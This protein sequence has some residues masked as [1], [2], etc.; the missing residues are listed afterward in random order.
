MGK[1]KGGLGETSLISDLTK[2][3]SFHISEAL[4]PPPV[5][6]RRKKDPIHEPG[7]IE[8]E[9]AKIILEKA[10]L[11][12]DESGKVQVLLQIEEIRDQILIESTDEYK[13]P[14]YYVK[15][16]RAEGGEYSE[17][18][19]QQSSFSKMHLRDILD[20]YA[21]TIKG[22]EVMSDETLLNF[23]SLDDFYEWLDL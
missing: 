16:V 7:K 19:W 6:E 23:S 15:S 8:D 12:L 21:A 3:I 13:S 1:V 11:A 2:P 20:T 17:L 18:P 9:L 5:F 10:A 22:V 4:E 14:G